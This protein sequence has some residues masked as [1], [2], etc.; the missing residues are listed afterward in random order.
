MTRVDGP[1]SMTVSIETM[2]DA[3]TKIRYESEFVV[4]DA[5]EAE[6]KGAQFHALQMA[7]TNG[8]GSAGQE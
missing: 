5:D 6:E 3:I 8:Y 1:V 2:I 4:T 7:W